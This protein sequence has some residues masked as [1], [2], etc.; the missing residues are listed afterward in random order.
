MEQNSKYILA[1]KS[2]NKNK[3]VV[4]RKSPVVI[5]NLAIISVVFLIYLIYLPR[6][7]VGRICIFCKAG[8]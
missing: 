3:N 6:K 8:N 1:H 5:G 2:R 7:I 4:H